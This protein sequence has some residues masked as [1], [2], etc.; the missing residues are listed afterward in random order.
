MYETKLLGCYGV[1]LFISF[2]LAASCSSP[3][4]T[5]EEIAGQFIKDSEQAFEE[6]DIFELKKLIS[7]NYGDSQ[8]RSADEI[9]S[10]AAMYIRSSKSI[11]LLTDLHSAEYLEERIQARVLAAFAARPISEPA[12]LAQMQADIYWFDIELAEENGSWKLT[13]A[14]WRQAMVDDFYKIDRQN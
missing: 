10:I 11:Y 2:L 8:N 1:V 4:T 9:I 12:V 14:Q 7:S 3:T 6:R 13:D 5:P